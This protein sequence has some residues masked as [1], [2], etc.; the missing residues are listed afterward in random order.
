MTGAFEP[1]GR[2]VRPFHRPLAT[3]LLAAWLLLCALLPISGNLVP[4]PLACAIVLAAIHFAWYRPVIAWRALWPIPAWYLL[5]VAGMLWT[6]NVDFGLFDL[7][8]K[9]GMVLLPIMAAVVIVVHPGLLRIGMSAFTIGTAMAFL[10]SLWKGWECYRS[11][12]DPGCF[13]Q[14]TF[15]FE[16]HPSYAAWYACWAMAWWC[17]RA[18]QDTAIR[19][20]LFHLSIALVMLIFIVMLASKSGVIGALLVIVVMA[21]RWLRSFA[22]GRWA[23]KMI[24]VAV[25]VAAVFA[26]SGGGLVLARME[27]AFR[28]V[29]MAR[30]GD[31]ALYASHGGSEMRLVAWQCSAELL[32]D[33]PWGTGTGDVKDEL[34]GCYTA[35]GATDAV[36][37]RLNAHCQFLQGGAALG[38]PGLILTLLIGL[39]PLWIAV[40]QRDVLLGTFAGLF[41]VNA[42]VESVLEVQAGVLFMGLMLG[43]LAHDRTSRSP[44]DHVNP[45]P[46]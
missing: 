13:A 36:E 45:T 42:A 23:P 22:A 15:S 40:R 25:A 31:P 26:S 16:L 21:G 24:L 46:P 32:A 44:H 3:A 5:H 27:A 8:V 6:T 19:P 43:L 41:F 12:G 38:W 7:Q 17:D 2:P 20:R 37:K 14:T 39:V 4:V 34:V 11:T 35:K 18:M 1:S 9:L 10:L 28:A 33:H 29:E 30:H